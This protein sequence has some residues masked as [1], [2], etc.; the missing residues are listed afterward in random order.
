[1]T[2]GSIT[3]GGLMSGLDT[4]SLISR[5]MA[6]EQRPI[7]LLQQRE[8]K[9]QAQ[10]SGVASLKSVLYGVQSAAGKLKESDDFASFSATSSN[11]E[12]LSVSA[13]DTAT[14]GH[15]QVE[16]T[17]LARAQQVRSAGFSGSDA[18]VGTGILT[19]QV[20]TQDSVEITI[21]SESHTLAGIAAAINEAE[22]G[23][24]AGVVDDGNGNVYLTLLSPETGASNTITLTVSDDDGNNDDASGL[25]GLYTDSAAHTLTETQAAQNAQVTVNGI[26]VERSG[27]TI[28]DL[29]D[30]VTL[31]LNQEDP[32]KPVT[33]EIAKDNSIAVNKVQSLVDKYNS[34]VDSLDKLQ[35]YDAETGKTGLLLGDSATNMIR[36]RMR[37]FLSLQVEGVDDSVNGLSRLGIE[38]DRDGK[39]SL[40]SD[41]LTTA[42]EDHYDDVVRFFTQDEEGS[43]GL[44]VQLYDTLDNYA[45]STGMLASKEDGLQA[46]IDDIEDQIEGMS[47]RLAQREEN[48]RSQFQAL[49]SLL[50][51]YQATETLMNQQITN[52]S[53]LSKAIAN[54]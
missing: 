31:S 26:A 40:D 49:E 35:S 36:S 30:G 47:T 5:M 54:K 8:A 27:N 42:L 16:V 3:A 33:V 50:A 4:D 29:L 44:A 2:V 41:T 21:D 39:L 22:A 18:T 11:E 15:Y 48:L 25:S 46:S 17:H 1:M 24:T 20:G 10:I 14:P 28:D 13:S 43:E 53:N 52:L 19:L 7:Q 6:V 23:V 45:K 9:Y 37:R 34:L 51:E 12:T 32:G 38:V